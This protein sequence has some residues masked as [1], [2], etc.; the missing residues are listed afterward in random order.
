MLLEFNKLL[1][2]YGITPTGI[3]HIG[4]HYGQEHVHYENAKCNHVVYFE[5]HPNTFS[6]LQNRLKSKPNVTLINKALGSS[7][8]VMDM[9]CSRN[10]DG[11]CNSLLRPQDHATIY[12]TI[13]FD[14]TISV[15]VSTLDSE[16]NLLPVDIKKILNCISIDVQGYELEVFKGSEKILHQIDCIF[17]E[18]N[19]RHMYESCGLISDLDAFLLPYGFTRVETHDTGSGWGDAFYLKQK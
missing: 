18:V 9:Y 17:T 15:P 13:I 4:A 6:E 10:M 3:L 11:M 14:H 5:P 2:K 1:D 12:S 7:S 19:F 8:G 16:C